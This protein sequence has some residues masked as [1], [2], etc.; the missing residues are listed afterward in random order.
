MTRPTKLV[1]L[2][3]QHPRE[4]YKKFLKRVDRVTHEIMKEAEFEKKFKVEVCRNEQGQVVAVK[5]QEK[6]D[7]LLSDKEKKDLAEREERKKA[8]RRVSC[9]A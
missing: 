8:A 3:Q 6:I 4:T 2:L 5:H 1:P 9:L 7:P